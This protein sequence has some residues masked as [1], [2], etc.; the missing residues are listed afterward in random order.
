MRD[1]SVTDFAAPDVPDYVVAELRYEAPV[2][3]TAS[4]FT[5]PAAAAPQAD[6]LNDVL[7]RFD[8]KTDPFAART[9]PSTVRSRVEVAAALPPEPSLRGSPI[10][11]WT[12]TLSTA[13]SSRSCPS[14]RAMRGGS[15]RPSIEATR[16]GRPT[17][18]RGRCR[19]RSSTAPPPAAGTSSLLRATC[20]PPPDGIGAAEVWSLAGAKGK[21][22]TI[23]DIEGAWN[24]SHED[25]PAG[26]PLIGGTMIADLGWRNHGTAVLGEMISIPDAKGSV[27]I[28][29]EAKAVVHSAVINGVF[30]AAGAMT[31]AAAQL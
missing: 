9:K 6:R 4:H 23:C 3:F 17:W 20:T 28:S 26:I 21:G 7:A 12:R 27:G 24:R 30:N 8:I 18:R 2:A 11:G 19:R 15:P 1:T 10:G 13:A 16:S 22:V 25:L 29:H 5:A 31:N 14:G